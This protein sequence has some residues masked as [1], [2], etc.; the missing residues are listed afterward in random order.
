MAE[1]RRTSE[2]YDRL[3][4]LCDAMTTALE[5][6]PERGDEKCIIFLTSK[7]D[8][9]GGLV[10][11][12]YDDDSEA[13]VDLLLQLRAIFRANGKQLIIAPLGGDSTSWP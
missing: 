12:G 10:M 9:R 1:E 4:R 8:R 3:T 11:H 13:I 2:P 6:H 7:I 5:A